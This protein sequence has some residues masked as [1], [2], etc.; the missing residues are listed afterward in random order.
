MAVLKRANILVNAGT[1]MLLRT[2]HDEISVPGVVT[3]T[4]V[5]FLKPGSASTV[6]ASS[7]S[8]PHLTKISNGKPTT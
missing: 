3:E 6:M 4:H 7:Q 5:D 8:L 1:I 2:E